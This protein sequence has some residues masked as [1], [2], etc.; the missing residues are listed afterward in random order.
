M[1]TAFEVDAGGP[2]AMVKSNSALLRIKSKCQ[3]AGSVARLRSRS[4]VGFSGPRFCVHRRPR[5]QRGAKLR[6]RHA[7]RAGATS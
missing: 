7:R 4:R 6:D 3:I 2:I 1:P 5:S